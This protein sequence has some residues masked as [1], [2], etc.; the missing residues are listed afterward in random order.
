MEY[1]QINRLR[2]EV[3]DFTVTDTGMRLAFAGRSPKNSWIDLTEEQCCH[4]LNELTEALEI[5]YPDGDADSQSDT[6]S[7][8]GNEDP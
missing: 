2:G 3:A 7:A 1:T 8:E 6:G 5:F 4:L